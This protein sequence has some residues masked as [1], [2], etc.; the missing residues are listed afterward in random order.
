MEFYCYREKSEEP[1]NLSDNMNLQEQAKYIKENFSAAKLVEP[2]SHG[3]LIIYIV[4]EK[5]IEF[6]KFLRDDKNLSFKILLD[7]FGADLLGI[8][9]P[10]FEVIYNLLSLKLNNRITI[11]VALNEG[12]EVASAIPAFSAAGWFERE[13]F[14]M[15][16]IIFKD[17]P[18]LR[19]ILTDYGFEGHPMRK[20][21]P[22][23]GYKEVRYDEKQ[24]K[25]V[26]E[27]VK[28]MQEFRNFDFE[29]PWEGTQYAISKQD[30]SKSK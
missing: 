26:Y 12:E 2:I 16:G 14:D 27:P 5:N 8:R 1:E 6:L 18:D 23:T 13:V 3:N 17:H 24:K 9:S 20:D 19:R 21:F 10:R 28:L 11:K 7:V 4:P 22:L 29:M 25:V 30:E 15:Y